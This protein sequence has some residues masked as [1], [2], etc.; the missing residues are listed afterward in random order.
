M[1]CISKESIARVYELR[2]LDLE[3]ALEPD[4]EAAV[5]QEEVAEVLQS[6]DQ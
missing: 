3:V 1:R 4:Q 2:T 5:V 6:L